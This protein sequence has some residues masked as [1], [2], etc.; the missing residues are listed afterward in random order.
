MKTI[1]LIPENQSKNSIISSSSHPAKSNNNG[2]SLD[3]LGRALT[4]VRI[5]LIDKCNFRCT[6][7]MPK[8]VFNHDYQFLTK[9]DLLSFSEVYLLSS[10]FVKLGT[11]KIRLTG[12]EPLLRKNIDI[13]IKEIADLRTMRNN[14]VEIALTTNGVLLMDKAEKLLDAGLKRIT[15]SLD[16]LDQSIFESLSDTNFNVKKILRGIEHAKKIG[17]G[18]KVNMVVKRGVNDCQIIPMAKYFKENQITLRFIEFMDVGSVNSWEKQKVFSSQEVLDLLNQK[19]N[20]VYAGRDNVSEVS[21]KWKYVDDSA[22]IGLISSVSKPFCRNCSRARV[23]AEG[24]LYTCLF[25]SSGVDLKPILRAKIN[26]A[27]HR[28]INNENR[29]VHNLKKNIGNLWSLRNDRYSELRITNPKRLVGKK[30]EM[31]YIGG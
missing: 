16:S 29:I 22:E 5:S 28:T 10:A 4:D 24:I 13:L 23:S 30:I 21:E 26:E 6:Y 8:S 3:A 17:L 1:K 12:G 25:A 20:F 15:V 9:N 27:K 2:Q 19:F 7:C 18:V 14:P 11:E 31:S